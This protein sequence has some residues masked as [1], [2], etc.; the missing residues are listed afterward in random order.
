M[1]HTHLHPLTL[2]ATIALLVAAAAH[3][4]PDES[5]YGQQ[6][7]ARRGP[8]PQALEACEALVEGDACAFTGRNDEQLNG[9]CFSPRDEILACRPEGHQG[10]G[11]GK[12]NGQRGETQE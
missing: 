10:R 11:H 2:V 12:G 7:H 6:R 4:E 1:R 9:T 5:G 8:P 3:A